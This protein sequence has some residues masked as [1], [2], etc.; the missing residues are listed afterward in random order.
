MNRIRNACVALALVAGFAGL[1][2]LIALAADV[3][4]A[5]RLY[6][7]RFNFLP[8]P[9]FGEHIAATLSDSDKSCL[10]VGA[11][12]AREGFDPKQLE[13]LVPDTKFYNAGTTG[14]NTSVFEIE[15]AILEHYR[16]H[17]RCIIVPMH[18]WLLFE[19]E[20]AIANLTTTEYASQLDLKQLNDLSFDPLGSGDRSRV[21]ATFL[22]PFMKHAAQ[23]NRILRNALFTVHTS[24]FQDELPRSSYELYADELKPATETFY[25]DIPLN[26]DTVVNFLKQAHFYDPKIYGHRPPVVS[27]DRA[28]ELFSRH[29]DHLVLV[30]MPD[31]TLLASP[32]QF[33]SP[34][35]DTVIAKYKSLMTYMDCS[36]LLADEFFIDSTHLNS[37]GRARLSAVVGAA[38]KDLFTFARQ[39]ASKRKFVMQEPVRSQNLA[40]H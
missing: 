8:G 30:K 1:S 28:L 35:F 14:G 21:L 16:L 17:Y 31:S 27:L 5:V 12:T 34:S 9:W 33:G 39:D 22:V 20:N 3:K 15:A 11:S 19:N 4:Q 37:H 32:N 26:R 13:Q 18:P 24:W 38:L 6:S 40:M 29:T 25:H 10:I 2:V 36:T 23:L 7:I